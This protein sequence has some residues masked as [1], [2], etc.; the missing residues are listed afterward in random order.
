[1][2]KEVEVR[3]RYL[4]WHYIQLFPLADVIDFFQ[5]SNHLGLLSMGTLAFSSKSKTVWIDFLENFL[6][7]SLVRFQ[8]PLRALT[9]GQEKTNLEIT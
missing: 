9:A 6:L 8:A 5:R 7:F 3:Q 1:M 2:I 4:C